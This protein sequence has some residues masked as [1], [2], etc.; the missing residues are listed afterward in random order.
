MA[1]KKRTVVA[2]ATSLPAENLWQAGIYVRLSVLYNGKTEGESLESQINY[3]EQYVA[4]HSELYYADL[5]QDNGFTGTN[6]TRPAW[7]RLL[8][9]ISLYI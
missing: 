9:D 8:T 5:Y 7:E 3:L 4:K 2:K 6:F 1:R